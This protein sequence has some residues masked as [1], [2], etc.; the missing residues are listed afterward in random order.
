MLKNMRIPQVKITLYNKCA[1][2]GVERVHQIIRESIV[3]SSQKN[4]G[5]PIDW[6][7]HVDIAV[8][9]HNIMI[10]STTKYS[11]YYLLY[12][13]EL[14]LPLDLTEYMLLV[15]ECQHDLGRTSRNT[16]EAYY[17]KSEGY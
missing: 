2:G 5:L 8:F 1:N 14:M 9:V 12:G 3:R 4:K 11:P 13:T 15:E 10:S 6:P 16:N 7:D 17:E